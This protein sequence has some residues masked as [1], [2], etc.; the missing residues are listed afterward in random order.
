MPKSPRVNK[1]NQAK[2]DLAEIA[3]YYG[4]ESL[5]LELRFIEAAEEAFTKLAPMPEQGAKREYFH[6]KLKSLRM[7]PIP[8]FPKILIFYRPESDGIE[9][10]RVLHS[11]RD[12]DTL[13]TKGRKP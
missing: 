9:V 3:E 6:P 10:V 7:W 2:Q 1:T 12:I 5:D 13:F 8:D 11:S 4:G